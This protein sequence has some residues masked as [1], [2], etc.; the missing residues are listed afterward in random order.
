MPEI[1]FDIVSGGF[2]VI[3]AERAKRPSDWESAQRSRKDIPS[4]DARC[5]FCPGNEKLT[6]PE[7][8]AV[9]GESPPDEPG[10]TIRVVPNKFPALVRPEDLPGEEGER[11]ALQG[12]APEG[13]HTA[14]YWR[15]PGI[16]AHEVV[17]EST[18]HNATLGSYAPEHLACVLEVLKERALLL[19]DRRETR[20]VQVFKNHGE[21]GG[22]SL[23]HPHFQVIGLPVLPS[24]VVSEGLRQREYESRAGRCLFCDMV[25]REL[26]KDVRV[27]GKSAE[28]VVLSP[29]ASGYSFEALIV[30]RKHLGSFAE[31][32]VEDNRA[33]AQALVDLFRRYEALFPSLPYNMVFHGIPETARNRRN[34]PYHAHIHV[35]PRLN[36]EAGLELGTGVHI[37]PLPPELATRQLLS[38]LTD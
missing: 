8:K 6:P 35:Y 36:A 17:V 12:Q 21:R 30:P 18:L 5:P 19:Y 34:W 31:A 27:V 29:F 20:Y 11:S 7:V 28:F 33:L 1:R 23:S 26:E 37:N 15:I 2:A 25:E 13:L 4:S 10:W 38:A 32:G 3:A 22:A 14:M 16:G 24:A 9:R